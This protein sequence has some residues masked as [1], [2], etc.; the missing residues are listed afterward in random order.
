MSKATEAQ[1]DIRFSLGYMDEAPRLL[2][3][4]FD[5]VFNR[6]CWN[7]S[8]ADAPFAR[9]VYALIKPGGIGYVDTT[10]SRYMYETL[11]RN[12]RMRVRLSNLTGWRIGH[13]FP[14]QGRIAKLIA[15]EPLDR[16]LVDYSRPY[17]D[18]V[19]FRKK[20]L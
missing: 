17:S 15:K 1:V 8:W 4:Q 11:P 9:A 19:L 2:G 6:I 20:V 14:P 5:V 18:R 16:M 3:E 12:A 13:A 10:H 7:Y